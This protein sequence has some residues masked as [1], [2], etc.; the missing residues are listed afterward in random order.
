MCH[1]LFFCFLK[2]VFKAFGS[3]KFCL[4]AR[5]GFKR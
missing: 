2:T 4:T 3:E 1:T 5:L